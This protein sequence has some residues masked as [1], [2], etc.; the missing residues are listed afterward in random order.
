MLVLVLAVRLAVGRLTHARDAILVVVAWSVRR[1]AHVVYSMFRVPRFC[2]W[3]RALILRAVSNEP[4]YLIGK[5]KVGGVPGWHKKKSIKDTT[6]G[7][8]T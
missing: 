6:V 1:D 7:Q 2:L 8:T 4:N 3:K 5:I